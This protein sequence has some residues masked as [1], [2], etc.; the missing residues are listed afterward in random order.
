MSRRS[1]IKVSGLVANTLKTN[2]A[3]SKLSSDREEAHPIQVSKNQISP[4]IMLLRRALNHCVNPL[5]K[6]YFS[7]VAL[8][9]IHQDSYSLSDICAPQMVSC[10]TLTHRPIA[11]C[12]T[13]PDFPKQRHRY[14]KNRSR[15][16]RSSRAESN[17]PAARPPVRRTGGRCKT[18]LSIV[19]AA[20][21]TP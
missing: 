12:Q 15:G 7:P 14:R 8:S 6:R 9:D 16:R 13:F 2:S 11:T 18:A 21:A 3:D 1:W 5:Y 4:P 20:A 19:N 17:H 10:Q